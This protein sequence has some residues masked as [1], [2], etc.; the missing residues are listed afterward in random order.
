MEILFH[1][2]H[3]EL[4]DYLPH[5]KSSL[6]EWLFVDVRLTEACDKNFT[7]TNAADL[8]HSLFLDKEGKLYICN[9]REI[10]MLIHWGRSYALSEITRSVEHYLPQGSCEVHAHEPTPEGLAKV[11]MLITYK[12]SSASPSLADIRSTRRENVVLIADD[13]MYMR[14]LVKKGVSSQATIHE[15]GDGKEVVDAYNK[16]A[17]DILF[18]DIHMP[19]VEGTS[20]LHTIL[21]IDPK[22]Y[23]LMLSADSSR[24]N[25]ELTT[26]SGAKGFLT[27]PFTK[28]KLMEYIKKCPTFS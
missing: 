2:H 12:R 11:E 18:L 24:E 20:A 13:D 8:L 6:K 16:Y 26:K 23:V 28:D 7:I 1:K 19:N 10:L 15:V 17:P 21:T 9:G 3:K 4:L 22:A 14:M 25:V 27:K 5:I